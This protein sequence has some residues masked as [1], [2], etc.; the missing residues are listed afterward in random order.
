[1]GFELLQIWQVAEIWDG[2][3]LEKHCGF[4]TA[5]TRDLGLCH[6]DAIRWVFQFLLALEDASI[7]PS[8][9]LDKR[10]CSEALKLRLHSIGRLTKDFRF[11]LFNPE[12]SL[13]LPTIACYSLT[14]DESG[15][16]SPVLHILT[17]CV[18]PV[19]GRNKWSRDLWK[20]RDI[21]YELGAYLQLG[22]D[23]D[24]KKYLHTFFLNSEGP[25]EYRV[26]TKG[27]KQ[28]GPMYRLAVKAEGT[29]RTR[30]EELEQTAVS[31]STHILEASE[32]KRREKISATMKKRKEEEQNSPA[33]K[34][35][36]TLDL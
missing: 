10:V 14:F 22:D 5:D 4:T 18:K 23:H 12:R 26:P 34:R 25:H 16:L 19:N 3:F 1:M 13:V 27:K 7:M 6:D 31:S 17:R 8:K 11:V 2:I 20:H 32:K 33:F 28:E 21:M 15:W 36:K 9:M 35:A 29:V 30:D 24:M